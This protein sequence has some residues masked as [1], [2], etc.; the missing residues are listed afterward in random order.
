VVFVVAYAVI[1]LAHLVIYWFAADGDTALRH[2]IQ[3]ALTTTSVAVG[4]LLVGAVVE[5]EVQ[6]VLWALAVTV[7]YVGIFVGGARGWHVEAPGHFAERHGLVVIIAIGESLV[8]VAL[9]V[10]HSAIDWPLLVAGLLGVVLA[11][12]LW[13]TYF[14]GIAV[15]VERGLQEATGDERTRMARDVFTYLHM[16]AVTGIVLMAVG[17]R[18]LLGDVAENG[19]WSRVDVPGVAM[20]ALYGGGA[21][22]LVSLA[23]LRWR[24]LGRPSILRLAVAGWLVAA[25]SVMS[26][27]SSLPLPNVAILTASFVGLVAVEAVVGGG[28]NRGDEHR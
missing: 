25:G 11:I 8:S 28:G 10:S 7:D 6:L 9:A 16:P 19:A 27:A 12:A 4:L 3:Q 15:A 24:V 5:G 13:R 20:L 21:L 18:V 23:A 26:L 17:L 2:T 22:Y 1:R 14:S